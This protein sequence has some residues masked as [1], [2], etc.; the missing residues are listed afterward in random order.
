LLAAS[1]TLAIASTATAAKPEADFTVTPSTPAAGMEASYDAMLSPAY[2][3]ATVEWDLDGDPGHAFEA[4]GTSVRHTYTTPGER[5]VT[6]RVVK[7]HKVKALV[8]KTVYVS[9]QPNAVPAPAPISPSPIPPSP[10]PP[11]PGVL[12]PGGADGA[13]PAITPFPIVRIAGELLQWG[14][15]IRLLVVTAPSGTAV[16]ARC[17]GKG[18]PLRRLGRRSHGRPVRMRGLEG[19]LIAGI[20]LEIRVR[21]SGF[22]GKYTRFRI[23]GAG[24]APLRDDRCLRPDSRTPVGCAFP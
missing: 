13:T 17:L 5:Q 24:R 10:I 8:T 12:E 14:A 20:R 23:R 21:Q 7:E 22:V 1:G 6:M 16:S 15:R 18:C 9:A 3:R 4:Q 11:Q 2:L 19:R